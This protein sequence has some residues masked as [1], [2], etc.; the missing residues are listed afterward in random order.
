M[1]KAGPAWPKLVRR[2]M[3]NKAKDIREDHSRLNG[4]PGSPLLI[5]TDT[6]TETEDEEEIEEEEEV[7]EMIN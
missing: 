4:R 2:T 6:E 7:V 3:R 1:E 5:E